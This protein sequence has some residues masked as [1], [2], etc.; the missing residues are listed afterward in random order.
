MKR[1]IEDHSDI[2]FELA[3]QVQGPRRKSICPIYGM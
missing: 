3:H 1:A 2:S